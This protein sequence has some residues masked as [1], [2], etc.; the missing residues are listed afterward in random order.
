MLKCY[1]KRAIKTNFL[2]ILAKGDYLYLL[3]FALKI[4]QKNDH[5]TS[6]Y[7]VYIWYS[8]SGKPQN[9]MLGSCDLSPFWKKN[10]VGKNAGS[11]TLL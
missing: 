10:G 9:R 6:R 5:N 4:S 11:T 8:N 2:I 3:F 1:E 7:I